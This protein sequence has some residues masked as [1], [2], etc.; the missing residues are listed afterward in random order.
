MMTS[1]TASTMTSSALAA[2]KRKPVDNLVRQTS[3]PLWGSSAKT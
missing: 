2:L 1:P 3:L